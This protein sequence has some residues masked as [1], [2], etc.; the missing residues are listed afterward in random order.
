[1]NKAPSLLLV[2]AILITAAGTTFAAGHVLT[3]TIDGDSA[4]DRLGHAVSGAG[5]VDGDG[6]DDFIAGAYYGSG[7][8]PGYARV[9]SGRTGKQLYS[10]K[11]SSNNDGF[12]VSVNAAG[13]V[14]GDGYADVIV[15][16]HLDDT[17]GTDAGLAKVFSGKNGSVLYTFKGDGGGDRFGLTANGAGDVNADGYDDLIVGA[18]YTGTGTAPG[19]AKVFSGKD[20]KLLYKLKGSSNRDYYG[21][22]VAG[23]GDVNK[24]GYDDVVIGASFDDTKGTD[25]GRAQVVSGKDG[26][27]LYNWYG[28]R[29]SAY[30]GRCVDGAG[31]VNKDGYDDVVVGSYLDDANGTDSGTVKVYSGKDGSVL[32]TWYGDSSDDRLGVHVDGGGDLNN[33]GYPDIVAGAY[34]DDQNGTNCGSMRAYSGKDGS[35]LYTFYGQAASVYFGRFACIL[36]DAN[37]DGL[38]D[39]IAGAYGEDYGG[40]DTGRVYVWIS[41]APSG[42]VTINSGDKATSST[43]VTLT[44]TSAPGPAKSPVK[45][46]RVRNTEDAWGAWV[47]VKNTLAWTLSPGDGTKTVEVQFRDEAGA[48]SG[49]RTDTIVLDQTPPTGSVAISDGYHTTVTIFVTLYF[50]YLDLQSGVTDLRIRNE[51][52]TWGNWLNAEEMK[53]WTLTDIGGIRTVEAQFRDAA[54]N[55]SEIAADSIEYLADVVAPVID[56][57]RVNAGRLYILP[58]EPLEFSVY[59]RD[60]LGGA[61]VEAFKVSFNGGGVWSDWHTMEYGPRVLVER[62]ASSGLISAVV[63]VRDKARNESSR[64]GVT[65]YLLE[66]DHPWI[67]A[68]AK[69]AGRLNAEREV[70]AVELGL[71]KGDVLTV[72]IKGSALTKGTSLALAM[73]LLRPDGEILVEGKY[74]EDQ[75]KIQIKR[76]TVPETGR[77]L[78]ILR[79][80]SGGGARTGTYKLTAKVKQAKANKKLAGSFTGSEIAF[81]ATHGSKVKVTLKGEGINLDNVTIEGP[82]GPVTAVVKGKAGSVKLTA[83]VDAG[84]GTYRIRF[85]GPVTVSA[86]VAVKLPKIKG[87]VQE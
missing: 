45:E 31:D 3:Y 69:F 87:T 5:D 64:K 26:T 12:G 74:P 63:V 19:Y 80:E 27:V 79:S 38:D 67:G 25:S 68:G 16:A 23:A 51:G 50:S 13:D 34:Y 11:G 76:F 21:V 47:P 59:G 66:T 22:Y 17:G 36:G 81:E 20:G 30:C 8:R 52:G 37:G 77:Y 72:K 78:L 4:G 18:Y 70:D 41:P 55:V 46:M 85:A 24:D 1:M 75:E 56:S 28:D 71:V 54:G 35:T 86:K 40:T 9:Y 58:E 6:H 61:G 84:T 60:N 14:N 49:A 33:D 62:P 43:S 48:T 73:D 15:G 65:F 53:S 7:S 29:S 39:I 32:Y 2:A 82:D 10:F 83:I 42:T 44:L 57:L